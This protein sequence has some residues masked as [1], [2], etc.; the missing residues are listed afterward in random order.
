KDV[1]AAFHCHVGNNLSTSYGIRQ[2]AL[3]SVEY[4]FHGTT[5]HA[6]SSPWEG[7][8]AADAAKLMDIGFDVLREHLAPTHS[9]A[10]IIVDAGVQPNVVPDYAK[11]WWFFREATPE[12]AQENWNKATKI[13]E[14]ACLMTGTTFEQNVMSAVLP[15]RDN[16][17]M[18][19]TVQANIELVG[20]PE[21]TSEEVELAKGL[22]RINGEKEVGLATE[23]GPLKK[24]S[25][26]R[27]SNDSGDVTWAVPHG[28]ITFPS[29]VSGTIGHHWTAAII[30]ATSIAH[31]GEV[32]GAKVLAGSMIDL[33]TKPDLLAQAIKLHKEEI[34]VAPKLLLPADQK[35]PLDLHRAEM[36]KYR[37]LMEPFYYRP[38]IKFQ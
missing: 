20:L 7:K 34:P 18:A 27:S 4:I 10:S 8:S 9:S 17:I 16:K 6:G 19:E 38:T 13:A 24:A 30:P 3:V 11:I 32:A 22:Q 36:E 26:G 23:I 31:K 25:Q 33:L 29:N 28:R 14:G 12:G 1:D 2:Y 5:S 35:P 21:W 15:T 37:S